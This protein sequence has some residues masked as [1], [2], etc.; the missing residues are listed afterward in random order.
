MLANARALKAGA[1]TVETEIDG[2]A[3]V[4][5]PFPYQGKCLTWLREEFAAL[6][7][8]DRAWVD[9][10]LEQGGCA[11]LLHANI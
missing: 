10:L 3:W 7:P 5:N 2:Q 11:A 6:A 8:A 4:Q 9:A 1:A